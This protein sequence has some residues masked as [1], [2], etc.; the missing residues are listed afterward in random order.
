MHFDI[1]MLH[2]NDEVDLQ[3]GH[4]QVYE[5]WRV[6]VTMQYALLPDQTSDGGGFVYSRARWCCI[7]GWL[8][9]YLFWK[10][11]FM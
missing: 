10:S 3:D 8:L 6:H 4:I 7:H 9:L 5:H 11:S 1:N 2:P